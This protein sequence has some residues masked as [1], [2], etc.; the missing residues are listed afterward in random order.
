MLSLGSVLSSLSSVVG[1]ISLYVGWDP[2]LCMT[3]VALTAYVW[4]IRVFWSS[5][6]LPVWFSSLTLEESLTYRYL[7]L[8]FLF[9]FSLNMFRQFYPLSVFSDTKSS[10][11]VSLVSPGFH[12]LFF[13][14]CLLSFV[15]A[16]SEIDVC[17]HIVY[18]RE[19]VT[20]FDSSE[21][22]YSISV[23][24]LRQALTP[25]C[26]FR[27]TVHLH[28]AFSSQLWTR[29]RFDSMHVTWSSVGL[30]R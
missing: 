29:A 4:T 6:C 17:W 22:K 19:D 1:C 5:F 26:C 11:P 7:F 13:V 20:W 9:P 14:A 24:V 27:R 15:S 18:M 10:C 21:K 25:S 16:P 23:P 2:L 8:C 28:I 30:I 3:L 12:L